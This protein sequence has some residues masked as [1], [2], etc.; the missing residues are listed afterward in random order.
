[1]TAWQNAGQPLAAVAEWSVTELDAHRGEDGVVV[2]D[3]RTEAEF[4]K[5]HVPGAR[6]VPLLKLKTEAPAIAQARRVVTFCGSGYRASI[7]A[8]LLQQ[9]GVAGVVNTP[10]SWLAWK[11]AGLPIET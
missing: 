10:G 7:A 6:N 3:V 5:G 4:A 1:M 9:R 2:L 11:A 8:S